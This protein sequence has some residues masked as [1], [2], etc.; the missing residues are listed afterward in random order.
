VSTAESGKGL[1]R[2][3]AVRGARE[4]IEAGELSE[5]LFGERSLERHVEHRGLRSR[6]PEKARGAAREAG[7][8]KDAAGVEQEARAPEP[9]GQGKPPERF[10]RALDLPRE[11][12]REGSARSPKAPQ[13]QVDVGRGEVSVADREHRRRRA[14]DEGH[15]RV[16][17]V[18]AE[19]KLAPAEMHQR[20]ETRANNVGGAIRLTAEEP[21]GAGE[22]SRG[23]L[24]PP[25]PDQRSGLGVEPPGLVLEVRPGPGR[26][27]ELGA[28]DHRRLI[29]P[30]AVVRVREDGQGDLRLLR[31]LDR[32]EQVE[33]AL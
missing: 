31:V 21:L 26:C 2:P 16:R 29:P 14:T 18:L 32:R 25:E 9:E 23:L 17:E 3:G 27:A 10:P 8:R 12:A 28:A 4:R 30:R 22:V 33:G 20:G 1:S 19:L 15:R 24:E 6:S 13:L 11:R 7:D 5:L